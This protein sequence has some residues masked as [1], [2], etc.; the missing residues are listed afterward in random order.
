MSRFGSKGQLF[1][2]K[3]QVPGTRSKANV[4]V[5]PVMA[6]IL[7]L[8]IV[9][10]GGL[11]AYGASQDTEPD[12]APAPVVQNDDPVVE[13]ALRIV[14]RVDGTVADVDGDSTA[15]TARERRR[16]AAASR[17]GASADPF[18]AI[19]SG[20][21]AVTGTAATATPGASS[22][23]SASSASS[24]A[25]STSGSASATPGSSTGSSALTAKQLAE[26]AAAQSDARNAA[27]GGTTG[28]TGSATT[29][30]SGSAT[31][32]KAPTAAATRAQAVRLV[33][34]KPAKITLRVKTTSGRATRSKR[35][36]GLLVP[37]S[38][39]TVARVIRVS[40][41]NNVVT[42][43]LREGAALA[44]KQSKG[45]SCVQ[46]LSSG[47]CRLV[48]VRTGR[49]AV[50]RAPESASG[51]PGAVTALRVMA[52]WRGGYKVAG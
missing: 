28:S 31:A 18:A 44:G 8:V 12:P 10:G 13:R 2:R 3:D 23:G 41:S 14:Q 36:M 27:G 24:S 9:G 43:R 37:N 35:S 7:G 50:I 48:R 40:K 19:A 21:E 4:D 1:A 26:R 6:A 16:A 42:L 39:S 49:T 17:K 11:A 51:K 46:R 29:G 38:T 34:S 22:S 20:T 45:T 25:S 32:A 47:D 15:A 33:A 30:S 5:D 52:I